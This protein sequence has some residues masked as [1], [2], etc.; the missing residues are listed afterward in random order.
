M[1]E[2]QK[3]TARRYY[4]AWTNGDLDAYDEIVASGATNHDTQNPYTAMPGPEGARLTTEMYRAA[5]SDSRFEIDQQFEEGDYVITRWTAHGTNDGELMGMAA[6]GKTV[7]IG[8]ITINRFED[9]KVAEAWTNWDTLGMM[10][11][12]GVVPQPAQV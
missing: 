12:L 6:T 3:A 2:Q 10:Q 9:G 1:S 8:G 4:E 11:Q 7:V 5:F